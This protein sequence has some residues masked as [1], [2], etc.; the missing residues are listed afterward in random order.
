MEEIAS[1]HSEWTM[2]GLVNQ[3]LI[4]GGTQQPAYQRNAG[5]DIVR[6][7]ACLSVIASHYFLHSKF[8]TAPFDGPSMFLQGMLSSMV[9]GSDLYM[10]LTGFLCSNKTPNKKFYMSGIKVLQ[11]GRAHV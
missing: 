4:G 7:I 5:L 11:I 3:Q 1:K 8:N 9:I 2:K 6:T 10:I